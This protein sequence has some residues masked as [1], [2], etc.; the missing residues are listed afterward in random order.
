M[1]YPAVIPGTNDGSPSGWMS[2]IS[3]PYEN[4]IAGVR[5]LFY[6]IF[7]GVFPNAVS[8]LTAF[9]STDSGQ[10]WAVVDGANSPIT[11][12]ER[13]GAPGSYATFLDPTGN[14]K[15]WCSYGNTVGLINSGIPSSWRSTAVIQ[16]FDM[17]TD[18]WG[19]QITG[20]PTLYAQ[21]GNSSN[22]DIFGVQILAY[23][24][25]DFQLLFQSAPENIAGQLYDR[26]STVLYSGGF[27]APIAAFGVGETNDYGAMNMVLGD[28]GRVH[29]FAISTAKTSPPPVA[30]GQRIVQQ[31]TLNGGVFVAIAQTVT[32]NIIASPAQGGSL[33]VSSVV[34][35]PNGGSTEMILGFLRP[36][37]VNPLSYVSWPTVAR[38]NS[39][40]TPVWIEEVVNADAGKESTQQFVNAPV[41]IDGADI[42]VVWSAQGDTDT[43]YSKNSGSGWGPAVLLFNDPAGDY[44]QYNNGRGLSGWGYITLHNLHALGDELVYFEF[45]SASPLAVTCGAPPDAVLGI[46][47]SHSIPASGGTAPYSFAIIAGALPVGLTL[48]P[49]TGEIS[50]TPTAVQTAGFTVEVTDAVLDTADVD[51]SIEVVAALEI[52][53]DDPPAGTVGIAYSHFFPATGGVPPY[54]FSKTAGVLPPGLILNAATGELAG[55]PTVSG[56]FTFTIRVTDSYAGG[57]PNTADVECSI[58]IAGDVTISCN[59]PTRGNLGIPYTHFFTVS[60]GTAPYVFTLEDGTLP[61]GL[62]L[63]AATGELTGIPRVSGVYVFSIRATDANEEAGQVECSILIKRC[64][65]VDLT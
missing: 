28:G 65:L 19:A 16:S 52:T 38:A 50:G 44:G 56:L 35:R 59:N 51:C 29:C 7:T 46:V 40:D 47:Y 58:L 49:L 41:M 62:T 64:L 39:A 60:G 8:T 1:P 24:N 33:F 48:N 23:A 9:K 37:T 4:G 26:V 18:T 10:T 31:R 21:V 11:A 13:G 6:L 36:A 22:A 5:Y 14:N 61:P 17:N 12:A 30:F 53:C 43:W 42:Y 25:G 55:T 27:G 34:T 45:A 2:S 63:N 15:V 54:T 20:G 32:N 3:G 57:P